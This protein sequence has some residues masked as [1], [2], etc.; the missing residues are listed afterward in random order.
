MLVIYAADRPLD[1]DRI[2]AEAASRKGHGSNPVAAAVAGLPAVE[3]MGT[4]LKDNFYTHTI[5]QD[6]LAP[7]LEADPGVMLTDQYAPVDNL[8]AGVF[9]YRY[10]YRPEQK[11]DD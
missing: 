6:R 8:M 5:P 4:Q 11:R 9:R 2:R 10:R 7:F 3:V 1:Q